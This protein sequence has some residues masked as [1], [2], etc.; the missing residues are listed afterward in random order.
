MSKANSAPASAGFSLTMAKI[1]HLSNL[2]AAVLPQLGFVRYFLSDHDPRMRTRCTCPVAQCGHGVACPR[3]GH[4]MLRDAFWI[5][6]LACVSLG[7][8]GLVM[9]VGAILL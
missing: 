8:V 7:V 2:Y 3:A 6:V 9:R 4:V 1:Q 5:I